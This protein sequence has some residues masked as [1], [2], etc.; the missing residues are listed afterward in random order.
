MFFVPAL[1][2][3]L[4]GIALCGAVA[5]VALLIE[6]AER[7]VLGTG[8]IEGLVLAILIGVL[9]RSVFGLAPLFCAGVH[10]SAKIMLEIAIVLLGASMSAAA[11][12]AAGPGLVTGIAAAVIISL[13]V[14]FLIGRMM[15]L[16]R[17]LATLIACGTSICGNSAIAA[18]APVIDADHDD[19]AAAIAFTAV[20][21]VLFVF[22]LPL[23]PAV[24]GLDAT[25]YGIFAGLTVY[26]VPQVLAA[27]APMGPLA[28]QVGTLVKLIR[29]LMLGPVILG[30]AIVGGRRAGVKLPLAHLVPWFIV[31]FIAMMALR[32]LGVI[33]PVMLG[34]MQATSP[35][36]TVM[37]MA[38]LGLMVDL[39]AILHVGGRVMMAALMSLVVL[40]G[41]A[42]GLIALLTVV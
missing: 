2:R 12:A 23:L 5:V 15:G 10:F 11:M 9:M 38:A 26:A 35:I 31:G 18:T 21:G 39:R 36:L 3:L 40:S 7:H 19:V 6:Q 24:L 28:V 34:I 29:V 17:R 32:S 13:G 8:M 42:L 20:L 37:A 41:L 25:R 33:P 1:N 14:A 16:S 22:L 4:P 30:L 27:T